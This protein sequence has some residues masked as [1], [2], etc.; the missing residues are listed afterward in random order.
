MEE[1]R[2]FGY[3]SDSCELH[4][5]SFGVVYIFMFSQEIVFSDH[6]AP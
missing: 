1:Q 3:N 2:S 6:F 4:L 5:H